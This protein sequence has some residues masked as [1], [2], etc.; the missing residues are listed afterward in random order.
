MEGTFAMSVEM[1]IRNDILD[2]LRNHSIIDESQYSEGTSDEGEFSLETSIEAAGVDSLDL[3]AIAEIV[4]KKYDVSLSDERIAG[5]KT[6]TDLV[7]FALQQ[8][9]ETEQTSPREAS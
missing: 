5:I 3:L 2:Y 7:N 1:D 9:G 8:R 6:F 4:E